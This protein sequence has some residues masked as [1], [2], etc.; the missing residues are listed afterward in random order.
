M[1]VINWQHK[2]A[3][4]VIQS[5]NKASTGMGS[6]FIVCKV[7]FDYRLQV[8]NSSVSPAETTFT[9]CKDTDSLSWQALGV[10]TWTYCVTLKVFLSPWIPGVKYTC[11]CLNPDLS[12]RWSDPTNFQEI[13]TSLQMFN[14]IMNCSICKQSGSESLNIKGHG[15]ILS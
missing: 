12:Q 8:S 10:W 3:R 14:S 11:V 13:K 5:S 6:K 15:Q 9:Q 7:M 1:R 2:L 4:S